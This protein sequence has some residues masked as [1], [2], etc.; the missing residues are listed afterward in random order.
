[1]TQSVATLMAAGAVTF[2]W[3]FPPYLPV[4]VYRRWIH[5]R[6]LRAHRAAVGEGA[7]RLCTASE[8]RSEAKPS[9]VS[10]RLRQIDLPRRARPHVLDGERRPSWRNAE[11]TNT[12][13]APETSAS[14]IAKPVF[15]G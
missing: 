13:L 2:R 3:I 7:A 9:E 10:K 4:L 11:S 12:A 1:M 6:P 15:P 8:A 14:R 5:T